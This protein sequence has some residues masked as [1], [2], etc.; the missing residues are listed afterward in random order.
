MNSA[1]VTVGSSEKGSS[2]RKD[3]AMLSRHILS[4]FVMLLAAVSTWSPVLA[5]NFE[6]IQERKVIIIGAKAD[7]RPFGFLDSAGQLIGME[8]DMARA[9]AERLNVRL[10]TVP[11]TTANRIE[12][13]RQGRIDLILATMSDSP[14]RRETSGVIDP[15]YYAGGMNVLARKS[16]KLKEWEQLRG[17]RVC[18]ILGAYYNRRIAEVYGIQ[19]IAS[20]G[21]SEAQADLRAGNCVAFVQDSTLIAA[22]LNDPKWMDFEMPLPTIDEQPWVMAVPLA[23]RDG[24]FGRFIAQTI[25]EWHQTGYLIALEKK[26]NLPASPYLQMMHATYKDASK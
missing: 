4:V 12:F 8:I 18:G 19:V 14:K 15:P 23:E 26:W 24:A 21:V 6:E 17:R 13:L 10:E 5:G 20:P 9:I 1:M 11:I 7:Y 3:H 22:T 16:L 2:A 25:I